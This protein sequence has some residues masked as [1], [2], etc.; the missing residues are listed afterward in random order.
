M[1]KEFSEMENP[2]S[3]QQNRLKRQ[4]TDSTS[5]T[6]SK[7]EEKVEPPQLIASNEN[8][9]SVTQNPSSKYQSRELQESIKAMTDR[10]QKDLEGTVS[11]DDTE[12][13]AGQ[14]DP[15]S[16]NAALTQEV[17]SKKSQD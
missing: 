1:E 4:K 7:E 3:Q 12:I 17:Q 2:P 5:K 15:D 14:I 13:A 10:R 6:K 8:Q 11:E 16:V 9:E